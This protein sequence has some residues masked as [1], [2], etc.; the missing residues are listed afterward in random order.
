[1]N[2]E[3]EHKQQQQQGHP[4]PS[5]ELFIRGQHVFMSDVTQE[6]MKPLIQLTYQGNNTFYRSL[7]MIGR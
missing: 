2:N 6:T 7:I 1:M 5:T 4:D 3:E